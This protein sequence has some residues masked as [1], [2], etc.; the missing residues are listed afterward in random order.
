MPW[1]KRKPFR[2]KEHRCGPPVN[3]FFIQFGEGSLWRC[4]CGKVWEYSGDMEGSYWKRK[5]EKP[6]MKEYD[7]LLMKDD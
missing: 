5:F 7:D 2:S 6:F 4:E 3:W 1:V